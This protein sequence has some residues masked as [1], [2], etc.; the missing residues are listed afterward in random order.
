MRNGRRC[1]RDSRSD[2]ASVLTFLIQRSAFLISF[3][4]LA[5]RDINLHVRPATSADIDWIDALQRP[6][7]K[8]LGF[9]FRGTL[10]GKIAKHEV[11]IGEMGGERVGYVIASNKYFKREDLGVVYQ[12]NVVPEHR[13]S[14]VAT[15]LLRALFD[16]WPRG[17][18]L[19]C[20]WCAQDLKA[21]E[22]WEAMGFVPLAYRGG[23]AKKSRTH[24]FWQKR[25]Y[26]GD[27][28]TPWWFPSMTQGGAIGA[29][30]VVLPIPDDQHWSDARPVI[31][32]AAEEP[33]G[34][35]S[36][37]HLPGPEPTPESDG[38]MNPTLQASSYTWP[39]GV[40]E[41]DGQLWRSGKRLMT[42]VMVQ[43]EFG[44]AGGMFWQVPGDVEVV[45]ELPKP[46]PRRRKTAKKQVAA[47][48]IDPRLIAFARDLRDAWLDHI[49][50]DPSRLLGEAKHDVARLSRGKR[51]TPSM[52]L[53]A[54][55]QR[56]L[57][58]AA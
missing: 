23:S 33:V 53:P 30:R 51:P 13:R 24:I 41:R 31:F 26:A 14:L 40:E 46:L 5:L 11:L 17:V 2:S 47:K 18:K 22:F 9:M 21:N 57:P 6:E 50:A 8:S 39:K 4:M 32:P 42:A 7:S 49:N 27:V 43:E 29:D 36:S 3:A 56:Q 10:E 37:H 12:M 38:G 35:D 54:P 55:E 25:L 58:A 34:W 15:S 16:S 20:C 45:D 1:G 52:Q 44:D 28:T 48:K 19:C